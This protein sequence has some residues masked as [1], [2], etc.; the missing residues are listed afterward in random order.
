MKTAFIILLLA[1]FSVTAQSKFRVNHYCEN[2]NA[3][4]DAILV[5]GKKVR[6]QIILLAE[7]KFG[8]WNG[9]YSVNCIL[10]DYSSKSKRSEIKK[11]AIEL[12]KLNPKFTMFTFFQSCEVY[13]IYISSTYPTNEREKKLKYGYLGTFE[14]IN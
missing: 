7:M 13:E 6:Y 11:I 2:P 9:E 10:P 12:K 3:P 5:N 1:S 14:I 8:K 4:F